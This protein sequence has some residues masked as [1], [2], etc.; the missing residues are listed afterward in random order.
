[1]KT[2][3]KMKL[4]VQVRTENNAVTEYAARVARLVKKKG[5]KT[6]ESRE[7]ASFT[8]ENAQGR[9]SVAVGDTVTIHTLNGGGMGGCTIVKLTNR[10][11]HYTQ[12]EGKHVKTI[13]YD[14]IFSID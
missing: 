8:I 11:I 9:V 13:A 10:S 1:M 4:R 12:D 7:I 3:L 5:G 14:N 2:E 6:D